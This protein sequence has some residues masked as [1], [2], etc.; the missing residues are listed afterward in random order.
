MLNHKE[1]VLSWQKT[2]WVNS[3]SQPALR[4]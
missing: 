1:R 3:S 2:T 4:G